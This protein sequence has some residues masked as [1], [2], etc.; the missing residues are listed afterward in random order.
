MG[1]LLKRCSGEQTNAVLRDM[2]ILYD[3]FIEG[4]MRVV[5]VRNRLVAVRP[6][7]EKAA[8]YALIVV[9]E[10]HHIYAS[11]DACEAV[12]SLVGDG[13]RRMLLSDASQAPSPL[14]DS[15]TSWR[16]RATGAKAHVLRH[17][18]SEHM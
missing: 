6:E 5:F 16:M 9:D 10:A 18:L 13:T 3:P 15:C 17:S 4:P 14:Y 11:H 8:G 12:E 2:H 7:G 1:W